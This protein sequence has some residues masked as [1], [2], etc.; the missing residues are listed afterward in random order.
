MTG[1]KTSRKL[2]CLALALALAGL[3]APMVQA[4]AATKMPATATNVPGTATTFLRADGA[5]SGSDQ[6]AWKQLSRKGSSTS[7]FWAEAG[8]AA[9]V[10]VGFV[11]LGLWGDAA[12]GGLIFGVVVV[13]SRVAP[14]CR[15][16]C[17]Q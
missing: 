15:E 10:L 1:R 2:K 3:A 9:A 7:Y 8:I 17:P 14:I 16:A 11:V 12:I 13:P 4:R 6:F 5:A